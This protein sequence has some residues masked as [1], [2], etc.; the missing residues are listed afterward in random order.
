LKIEGAITA[1]G[2][3]IP[4][5]KTIGVGVSGIGAMPAAKMK[6]DF[7][8][9][10]GTDDIINVMCKAATL[11]PDG[12]ESFAKQFKTDNPKDGLKKLHNMMRDS[13]EYRADMP[14][15]QLIKLPA[16][17]WKDG[18]GDCKSYTLFVV[19][20]CKNLGYKVKMKFVNYDG[21]EYTHV[22]PVVSVKG[23]DIPVD[24]VYSQ[25]FQFDSFGTE[26]SYKKSKIIS[27]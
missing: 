25:V 9:N 22:Y 10:G 18:H 23:Q 16:R 5:D 20:I 14:G 6:N 3:T 12:L 11:A 15:E 4:I 21:T 27:V 2:F 8:M 24:V 26:K 19:G 17:L 7:V 13:I 1:L